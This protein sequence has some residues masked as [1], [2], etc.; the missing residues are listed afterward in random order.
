MKEKANKT[1]KVSSEAQGETPH[2]HTTPSREDI[3]AADPPASV[4]ASTRRKPTATQNKS[5]QV[6]D[7]QPE[8]PC[9]PA[10]E[11]TIEPSTAS[12]RVS[13]RHRKPVIP[14]TPTTAAIEAALDQPQ[15]P[16]TLKT[17]KPQN[18]ARKNTR[19]N[20]TSSRTS[21]TRNLQKKNVSPP[22]S[23]L[24]RSIRKRAG[25]VEPSS[26][27]SSIANYNE[28]DDDDDGVNIRSDNDYDDDHFI[29]S[30]KMSEA[31]SSHLRST[32]KSTR[33]SSVQYTPIQTPSQRSRKRAKAA[34]ENDEPPTPLRRGTHAA[35]QHPPSSSS[36]SARGVPGSIIDL[37]GMQSLDE[38][39]LQALGERQQVTESVLAIQKELAEL[40]GSV[41]G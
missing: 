24:R 17:T 11:L 35:T 3:T 33:Q 40:L 2:R 34:T 19:S 21:P 25:T 36:A 18:T 31:P 41:N 6:V 20:T 10:K 38:Y 39:T 22:P 5:K 16:S 28:E 13:T 1:S 7:I 23:I 26:T 32:R 8:I 14:Q 15:V 29:S 37:L 12:V 30:S 27:A 4:R 9:T